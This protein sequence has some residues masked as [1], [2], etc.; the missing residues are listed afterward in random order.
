M[1][2]GEPAKKTERDLISED[3]IAK[4]STENDCWVALHGLVLNLPKDFL[5]EHPGGPDVITS[6]A[7]KNCTADFEDIAHSDSAREWANKYIIGRTEGAAEERELVPSSADAHKI[8]GGGGGGGGG[9]AVVPAILVV[10]L[11]ILYFAF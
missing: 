2:A 5:D 1:G 9:G 11:A 8:S 3:E 4:H 6:L 7:G 10:L